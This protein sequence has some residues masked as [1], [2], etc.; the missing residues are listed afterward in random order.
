M[1]DIW[2]VL[3]DQPGELSRLGQL[4]GQG[5]IGIEGGGVF[6]VGQECHAHFLVAEGR[7]AADILSNAGLQVRQVK[8]PLIRKLSQTRCGELGEIAGVLAEHS[9]NI[10]TQ[11]SDHSNHL[12]LMTD[13]DELAAGLTTRWSV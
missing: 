8:A 12:I 1:Y 13:N 3:A 6:T 4:L 2:V 11:Y 9:I 5:N 10:V 7:Q